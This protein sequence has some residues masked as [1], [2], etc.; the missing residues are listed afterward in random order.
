MRGLN[1]KGELESNKSFDQERTGKLWFEITE[2]AKCLKSG[3]VAERVRAQRKEGSSYRC[4]AW[5]RYPVRGS[6][7]FG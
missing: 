1:N 4:Q 6:I 7:T 5:T 2:F 3:K